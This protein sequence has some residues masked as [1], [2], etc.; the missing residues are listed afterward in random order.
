MTAMCGPHHTDAA[1]HAMPALRRRQAEDAEDGEIRQL[2]SAARCHG[3]PLRCLFPSRMCAPANPSRWRVLA[4]YVLAVLLLLLPV[5][6]NDILTKNIAQDNACAGGLNAITVTL[7]VTLP[8]PNA[9][10]NIELPSLCLN[11]W[12]MC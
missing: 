2:G 8:V 1:E 5:S 10:Q 6:A 9:T 3:R 12:N 4:G 7:Q 11:C